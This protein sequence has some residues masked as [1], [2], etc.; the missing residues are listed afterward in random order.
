MFEVVEEF[1]SV[2]YNPVVALA[3]E[4]HDDSD[5]TVR[6]FVRGI[7]KPGVACRET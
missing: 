4:V 6:P 1:E 5:T 2:R 3:V 7:C